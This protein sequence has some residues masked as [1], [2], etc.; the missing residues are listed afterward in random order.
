MTKIKNT[1]KG[2]AKKTL[3]MSLV[4]AMLATSNVPVWA[5]EFSDGSDDVAVATEAPATET[6]S[7]ET[8]EA[9]IVDDT[10]DATPASTIVNEKDMSVDLSTDTKS[11]VWG[12]NDSVKVEIK[13]TVN[14]EGAAAKSWKF[15][16]VDAN[17]LAVT[18]KDKEA[19]K[20]SDMDLVANPALAGKTLTLY[21]YDKDESGQIIYD[22]NTGVTVTVE[23]KDLS[24]VATIDLGTVGTLTYNGFAQAVNTAATTKDKQGNE[25]PVVNVKVGNETINAANYTLSSTSATNAGEKVTVTATAAANS[26]YTGTVSTDIVIGQKSAELTDKKDGD[27]NVV[28]PANIVANPNK[29]LS[30]QYTGDEITIANKDVTVKESK[31]DNNGED[32]KFSGADLSNTI[33]SAKTTDSAIGDR[34]VEVRVDGRLFK[35]FS[36]IGTPQA[37]ISSDTVEIK[38]RD[39]SAAGTKLIVNTITGQIPTDITA[40]ELITKGYLKLKGTEG[41]DLSK[42][43]LNKDYTLSVKAADGTTADTFKDGSTYTITITAKKAEKDA[44]GNVIGTGNCENEQSIQVVAT[45]AA[46]KKV[47]FANA[48]TYKPAYTGSEIKPS[49]ADLG[50]LEITQVS[51][52]QDVPTTLDTDA[53]EITGYSNNVN[54]STIYDSNYKPQANATVNIKITK[55]VYEG[56]TCSVKF[57][58]MPLEVLPKYITVAKTTSINKSYTTAAEYKLP[59]T[60]VAKDE[61]GKKVA[62]TL[63]ASDYTVDYKWEQDGATNAVGTEIKTTVTITN[64]NY[65]LGTNKDDIGK[66][67]KVEAGNTTKIT[68]KQLTDAM[69]VVNPSSYTYTGGK[70]VPNYAVLDGA[71]ALYKQ[72]DIEETDKIKAEYKEVSITDAVNVGTG[73]V[74]VEGINNLYAGKATGT[75][76][77]TP[78]N[79]SAVKVSID[80]QQYTGKQVRPRDFKVTLNGNDVTDQFTVVSYGTNVE[81]GKGTVVLKP[82]DGNKNFTGS[83]IT[84]EFN[85]VKEIITASLKAYDE[86]GFEVT[87]RFVTTDNNGKLVDAK[88]P[89]DFDGNAHT[90]AKV[91]LSNIKRDGKISKTSAKASDFEIKYVDNVSGK[92]VDGNKNIG[93]VYAVAKDGTGFTGKES[94]VTAD[95]TVIKGVVAYKAFSIDSVRFVARNVSLKNATYAAGLPVKPEVTVQIG[96]T[97]LVEGKDYT[98]KLKGKDKNGN[99]IDVTP[100]DVTVGNIYGVEIKGING[101]KGSTVYTFDTNASKYEKT[102]T[103]GVDKKNLK[104][105]KVTVKDGVVSVVNGYI[106]VASAEYTS[107]NNGDGT[108]TVTAVSTSKNYTGSVTVT[109]DGKAE[110]EKPNAPM[111][112]SVKV[113]GNKATAIL[114]GDSEGAAG[115]D[116]V[117]STDRDCITN[118]DYASV[119]KNQ[120]Q[121]STTFKY[122]QQGTYYAYCHAWKRDE[123][124]KK[125]FS[126]W[127]N[128]YPFVV[129][130]ITPDAPVITNVKVNGSTIKVTYK[131]AT[132]ATGYDVV[133][134]TSSKKENGETRPYNYGAHKVLNLKEGTVTAT[135]KNVP[136]GTWVV[137]MHAFNRTSEDG[138]KVF[139]PW[140][141][142]KKAT[143]K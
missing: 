127:S 126:D 105:C 62:K 131:A 70:I 107:K 80:D 111:I 33:I 4:V 136:K 39:L 8:A 115:Y 86:K 32:K 91:L 117:I 122:V 96:G 38:K 84:V 113:V 128:A 40:S 66:T 141:N 102:L 51:N 134:G 133:L 88:D 1:K 63:T 138:K 16:W 19:T 121:T 92:M 6:F 37:L 142:L 44:Q 15:R 61:T 53:Y 97:T 34:T 94:I 143:V 108:Y 13:G 124:G 11:V 72:G 59:V 41:S 22:I 43:E 118:K 93:Y 57:T 12:T 106:P 42:L 109:A 67:H 69:V 99:A 90:F 71:I 140:S 49:K 17:G 73:K 116:Y 89:F 114:S 35:N 100:T 81:A 101:Y 98:L 60:V 123:N 48:A 24:K 76:T 47:T 74:T 46:F 75:F 65:I 95:G 125:V 55:G 25:I 20:I 104:D 27:G 9:P 18:E 5:A 36:N 120:V 129:S 7:D 87:D 10:T 56:K 82:L 110:D 2:M 31:S 79:T 83:N 45:T 50:K 139:S 3:S 103:W 64:P 52:G 78:A 68:A 132:N 29:G 112:S 28:E 14:K 85:I 130:A 30:Y 21:V 119:N 58:I 23:K 54:A 77:I 137:G 135:F 26:A